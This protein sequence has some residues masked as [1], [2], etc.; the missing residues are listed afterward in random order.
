MPFEAAHAWKSGRRHYENTVRMERAWV[1]TK[2]LWTQ[3]L[4]YQTCLGMHVLVLIDARSVCFPSLGYTNG[5]PPNQ[6]QGRRFFLLAQSVQL[7]QRVVWKLWFLQMWIEL[8]VAHEACY[9]PAR[10]RGESPTPP[11]VQVLVAY[12]LSGVEMENKCLTIKLHE[13]QETKLCLRVAYEHRTSGKWTI[14]DTD[15]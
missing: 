14:G 8:F 2:G 1:E 10:H 4:K 7:P 6:G 13:S 5:L 12:P 9:D 3:W 11:R 15:P